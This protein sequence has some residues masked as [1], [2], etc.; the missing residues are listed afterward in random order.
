MSAFANPAAAAP[1]HR[2]APAAAT[3]ALEVRNLRAGYAG[4]EILK[5]VS[6][7]V[8]AGPVASVAEA[9]QGMEAAEGGDWVQDAGP[10]RLAPDPIRLDGESPPL[11]SAPPLLG[12]HTDEVM[13]E[14]GLG[15]D[16]IARLRGE[17]TVA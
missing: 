9:L 11:R 13:A 5:G 8:P 14:L 6:F 4:K 1:A 17:G 2:P 16:E 15:A 7:R 10:M 12:E 3:Y